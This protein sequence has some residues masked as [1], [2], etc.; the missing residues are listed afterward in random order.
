MESWEDPNTGFKD[1]MFIV[2][3]HPR[4]TKPFILA[5][6]KNGFFLLRF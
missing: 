1:S 4:Q 3:F 5:K 2:G 6:V